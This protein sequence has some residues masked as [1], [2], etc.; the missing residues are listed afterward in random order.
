MP[1]IDSA[2]NAERLARVEALGQVVLSDDPKVSIDRKLEAF[3]SLRSLGGKTWRD[4]GAKEAM[5]KLSWLVTSSPLA[6]RI[7]NV[8]A[9]YQNMGMAEGRAAQARGGDEEWTGG[10]PIA[11]FSKFSEDDQKVLMVALGLD[12]KYS[13]VG[14]AYDDFQ[15]QSDEAVA[16]YHASKPTTS[17]EVSL[18]DQ[19]KS[20]LGADAVAKVS[21]SDAERALAILTAK[22]PK[23]DK[24]T[25][26]L[27]MLDNASKA[28]AEAQAREDNP[29]PLD[30]WKARARN[31]STYQPGVLA[32]KSA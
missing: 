8:G 20:I 17:D 7:Q 23:T 19:A 32:D 29:S 13:S 31:A 6:Q 2:E 16:R 4:T 21:G 27:T 1:S 5:V 14:E 10:N 25:L 3:G 18:S 12:T 26:A 15:R 30:D 22:A 28:N 9:R 11:S 24:S